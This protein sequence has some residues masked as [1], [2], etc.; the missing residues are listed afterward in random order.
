MTSRTEL[1]SRAQ[2]GDEV[3][4]QELTESLRGELQVHCYRIVGSVHDAEDLVQETLMARAR[5]LRGA[6]VGAVLALPDRHES[7]PEP[8]ARSRTA[9]A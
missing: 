2:S 5:A 3:A 4:F 6:R 8:R 1:L 7:L 9:A